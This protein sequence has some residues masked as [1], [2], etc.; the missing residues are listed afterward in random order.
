MLSKVSLANVM[1]YIHISWFVL[2]WSH[3]SVRFLWKLECHL[4]IFFLVLL[5]LHV[6]VHC[7]WL[8][9]LHRPPFAEKGRYSSGTNKKLQYVGRQFMAELGLSEWRSREF[10]GM[11]LMFIIVFFIR[12]YNHYIGQW[13]FL[14]AIGI[15][16][17]K[18]VR[19]F[20]YHQIEISSFFCISILSLLIRRRSI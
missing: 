5:S 3:T 13:M 12:M 1:C 4:K 10:W 17:N 7:Y 11:L 8:S 15:P 6:H 16:V 2:H 18:W 20:V 9:G 14:N 19:Q